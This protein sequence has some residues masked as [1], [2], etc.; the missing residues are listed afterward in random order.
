VLKI[1][2]VDNYDSFTYNL[3]HYLEVEAEVTVMRNDELDLEGLQAFDLIVLSPGPGLPKD[4]G[5]LMEVIECYYDKKPILGIC[6]G[7]QAIAEFF[8]AKL[9]N[10]AFVKHGLSSQLSWYDDSSLLYKDM[11]GDIQVGRYHSWAVNPDSLPEHLKVTAKTK[12]AIM[13]FVSTEYDLTGIQYHPE[14]VLS[15]T[16]KEI[17]YNWLNRYI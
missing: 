1:A 14:S 3:K 16:G 11:K 13:S 4:A 9:Y 17:L 12:D 7:M 8:D 2:L 6:L 15:P 10:L 5:R